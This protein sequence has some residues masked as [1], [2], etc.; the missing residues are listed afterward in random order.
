M[1]VSLTNSNALILPFADNSFHMAMTSPPYWGL[2]QYTG[3]MATVWDAD[4]DC[5]HEWV[6]RER[7]MQTGG[8]SEKQ[9]SNKGV[10]GFGWIATDMVC[11]K[12]GGWFGELGLEPTPEMYIDHLVQIFREVRRVLHPTGTLWLNLGDSYNG[13]GGAGG[14]YNPGGLK[15][16][17]TRYPGRNVSSMKPL[18]LTGIPWQIA[19]ALRNDGW[20]LR[21]EIIWHK[22]NPM[23][24]SLFGWRWERHR[25]KVRNS[26]H[27]TDNDIR[28]GYKKMLEDAGVHKGMSP[29]W[30]AE[31]VECEGCE[32]CAPNDGYILRKANWRP[33]RSHEHLFMLSK[34]DDSFCDGY[35]AREE[36]SPASYKRYK[37]G[38]KIPKR[39]KVGGSS[40]AKPDFEEGFVF[41]GDGRNR[42][43]VWTIPTSGYSGA[44]F[45]TYPPALVKPCVEAGTSEKGVCPECGYPWV[46]KI[47]YTGSYQRRWS[48]NNAEGSPYNKQDSYA[49]TYEQL[50]WMPSC[51]CGITV[52][53]GALDP[54]TGA[55]IDIVKPHEPVP[56]TVFDPFVGSGTTL[57]V[58]RELGRNGVGVDLSLPYLI[59][60]AR[61]RLELDKID[62]WESGGIE[63]E[64][65]AMDDLPL[66][67]GEING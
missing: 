12:C 59:N 45:A 14:D 19:L 60:N 67:G 23:P 2:R 25:I 27:A 62:G 42:R 41:T 22:T 61:T 4:P 36:N 40:R 17:R 6:K 9:L 35:A 3:E 32:K 16:G 53:S 7:M 28:G 13:S 11:T 5:D 66:F 38:E 30:L 29:E 24:E 20:Y 43:T 34:T 54:N 55:G 50:G 64:E 56:A 48:V 37:V 26:N 21:S 1:T 51:D 39:K 10:D 15:E 8:I 46:R 49:N 63:V 52:D 57:I 33:T 47:R 65:T 44:H 31:W 58:A 18:D